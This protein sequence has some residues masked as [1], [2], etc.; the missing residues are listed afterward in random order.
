MGDIADYYRQQ[1]L[2]DM[3]SNE[4]RRDEAF[5]EENT[6]LTWRTKDNERILVSDMTVN[7]MI[8][9]LCA[10]E[11]DRIT[12]RHVQGKESW[13]EIFKEELE[14]RENEMNECDATESDLY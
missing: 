13:I 5:K 4:W 11:E 7:H 9:T 10:I 2:D 14:A 12:F 6:A 1:E 8:N 3:F